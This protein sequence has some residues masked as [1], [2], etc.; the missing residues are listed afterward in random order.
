[1]D[2]EEEE[3]GKEEYDVEFDDDGS[4]QSEVVNCVCGFNEEDGLMIQ[5]TSRRLYHPPLESSLS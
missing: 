2:T 5:V 1:M 4:Y 3:E